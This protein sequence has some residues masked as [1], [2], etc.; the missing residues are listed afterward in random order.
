MMNTY[1]KSFL[2]RGLMFGGFGPIVMGIVFF[3]LSCT[4]VEVAFGGGEVLLG[5]LSTYLLAFVHAGASVFNQI[6]HWSHGR[7]L[8]FHFLSLYVAYVACYA[9]NA[10]IP[11]E[12]IALLVFTGIFAATYFITWLCVFLAIRATE[13]RLNRSLDKK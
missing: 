5:I 2:L 11:F 13:R 8:F 6:E 3:V 7:S 12:P 9:V 1:V 4:S 10:W